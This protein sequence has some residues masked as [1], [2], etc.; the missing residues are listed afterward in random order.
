MPSKPLYG[1]SST[2]G[3]SLGTGT[4]GANQSNV[5]GK[6]PAYEDVTGTDPG[7]WSLVPKSTSPLVDAGFELSSGWLD[8]DGSDPDIGAH[9]GSFGLDP[10][11]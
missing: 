2:F 10:D 7:D 1:F 3:S 9:G 4:T 8:A 5:T 6:P 11:E